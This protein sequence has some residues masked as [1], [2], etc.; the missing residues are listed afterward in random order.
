MASPASRA[1]STPTTRCMSAT[2]TR[3]TGYTPTGTTASVR[4]ETFSKLF[5]LRLKYVVNRMTKITKSL[6]YAKMVRLLWLP[7]KFTVAIIEEKKLYNLTQII[8]RIAED[9]CTALHGH[10]AAVY[11]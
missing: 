3:D 5:L 2:V 11:Q 9:I 7:V 4:P 10:V 8:V 6:F 1:A